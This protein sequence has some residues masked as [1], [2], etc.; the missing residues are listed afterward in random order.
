VSLR[1]L[2][3]FT[4]SLTVTTQEGKPV[5][6]VSTQSSTKSDGALL[7]LVWSPDGNYLAASDRQDRIRFIDT[8]TWKV[9]GIHEENELARKRNPRAPSCEVNEFAFSGGSDVLIVTYDSSVQM[10]TFPEREYIGQVVVASVASVHAMSMDPRGRLVFR[11]PCK[12]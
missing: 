6:T 7:N 9:D 2:R 10:Y 12:T 8:R 3:P 1:V 4:L 11:S 5:H